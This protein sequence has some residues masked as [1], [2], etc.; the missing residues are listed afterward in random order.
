MSEAPVTVRMRSVV[1]D[2]PDPVALASFYA[3]LLNGRADVD[4]PTW[5]EVRVDGMG[6]KLAFQAVTD[7]RR[8]E[9]PDGLPQQVHLDLTVPDLE[10]AS[11]QAVALGAVALTGPV[12]EPGSVFI[13]HADPAGHPFCLCMERTAPE[14]S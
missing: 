8:P 3:G 6:F 1:I 5:C 9:W 7:Y 13:V 14:S 12:D 10:A 11:R 2:C 4:D